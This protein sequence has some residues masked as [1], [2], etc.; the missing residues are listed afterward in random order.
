MRF[1]QE[2]G[3]QVERRWRD[4]NY[5]ESAFPDIATRALAEMDA[6]AEV[7]PWDIVRSLHAG[8]GLPNQKGEEDKFGDLA[9]TLYRGERFYIDIYYWLDGTTSIHQHGFSGAFQVLLGSSIQ[10]VYDFKPEHEISEH[11]SVGRILLKEVQLLKRGDVRAIHPGRRLIHALF[12]LD[13]PSATITVRTRQDI[14]S[15]PQYEYLKPYFATNPFLKDASIYRKTQSAL[16]LL[17]MRHPDAGAI[18]CELLSSSDFHTAFSVLQAA[19]NHLANVARERVLRPVEDGGHAPGRP[20]E[21]ERLEALFEAARRRHGSLVDFIAPVLG[22]GQR[23]FTLVDLRRHVTGGEDRFFLA[24]ILNVPHRRQVLD[25]LRQRWPDKDPVEA[26]CE[27]VAHLSTVKS[28]RLRE[29]GLLGARDFGEAHLLVLRQLLEG[30]ADEEI[31]SALR[32]GPSADGAE[33]LTDRLDEVR[34]S[35]RNSILLGPLLSDSAEHSAAGS[36]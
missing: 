1:F 35:F 30:R 36:S 25:L 3:S 31:K 4:K 16:L 27:R 14:G 6:V 11:F 24:L 7:D 26:V 29:H 23:Q 13:R 19:F 10:S 9:V 18:L 32:G 28:L 5:S 8:E 2:L 15:L 22:E 12:H 17:R 34:T 20:D 21:M 33:K